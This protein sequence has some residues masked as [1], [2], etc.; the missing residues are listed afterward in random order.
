M[1][2]LAIQS[3]NAVDFTI[4][5]L[6]NTPIWMKGNSKLAFDVAHHAGESIVADQCKS[7]TT[8]GHPSMGL[9]R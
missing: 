6:K 4:S 9:L 8:V 3:T 5:K 1:Y 2:I 7:R